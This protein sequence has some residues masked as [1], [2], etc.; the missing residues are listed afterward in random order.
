LGDLGGM[1]DLER[2]LELSGGKP[3]SALWRVYNNL[4]VVID[5]AYS[6]HARGLELHADGLRMAE[7]FGDVPQIRWFQGQ[8]VYDKY[9]LGDFD[10]ALGLADEIVASVEA[11][12]P[13]SE[14]I[15]SRAIR[16]RIRLARGDEAGASAD[17]DASVHRAREGKDPQNLR[18]ALGSATFVAFELGQREEASRLADEL[19]ERIP[20]STSVHTALI[21]LTEALFGL[22]RTDELMEALETLS[23]NPVRNAVRTYARGDLDT[24]ADLLSAIS[25][26]DE[27]Y[28]RLQAAAAHADAGRRAEADAQLHR[29]LAFWRSVGATRYIRK[30]E[31]LLAATA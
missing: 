6:D 8:M 29:A 21:P 17:A 3:S 31:M 9:W 15:G 1:A 20:K 2:A 25:S 13:H 24:A 11:G 12:S 22:G 4:A 19:L 23:E 7:R 14:E 16:A 5:Y 27:A 26:Q 30:A 10:G 28:A 18:L